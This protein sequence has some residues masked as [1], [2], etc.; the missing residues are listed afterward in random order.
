MNERFVTALSRPVECDVE[1]RRLLNAIFATTGLASDGAIILPTGID[2]A[3]F[4]ENAVITDRHVNLPGAPATDQAA[5]VIGN[6]DNLERT[7]LEL[8]AEV[9][10]ADTE[11]G[12][13][14]AHLY[15]CNAEKR[16]YMRAWSIE[17]NFMEAQPISWDVARK[18]ADKYWDQPLADRMQKAGARPRVCTRFLLKM[19]AAVPNGADRHA[20]TRA[21]RE[22]NQVAGELVARMDFDLAGME[23]AD[24]KKKL[25]ESDE[26][27]VRLEQELQ[28]L[29]GEGASAAARGDSEAIL[30]AVRELLKI[31]ENR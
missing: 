27:I 5:A 11:R 29:R 24:L 3:R 15:G 28:A 7:S 18:L 30:Q 9:Q 6:A 23:L 14:Y 31:T 25:N 26:R 4:Q 12:R 21:C 8:V 17:G 2:V 1:K 13:E 10:F 22:G 20:L 16:A 19:V